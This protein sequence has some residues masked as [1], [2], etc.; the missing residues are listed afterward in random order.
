[1]PKTGNR[2][3]VATCTAFTHTPTFLMSCG[4]S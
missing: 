3:R 4:D 1:M 2:H